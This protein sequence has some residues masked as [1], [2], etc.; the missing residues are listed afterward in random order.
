MSFCARDF[1]RGVLMDP[2]GPGQSVPE[3]GSHAP[4]GTSRRL[5][6]DASRVA[7]AHI[8]GGEVV[9][10]RYSMTRS[11]RTKSDGGS[12]SP[13]ARAVLRLTIRFSRVGSSIGSSAGLA[14]LRIRST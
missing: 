13:R 2:T 4:A 14:P 12:V 1:S 8:P 3:R 5:A 10:R 6:C 7:M 9:D 11:A